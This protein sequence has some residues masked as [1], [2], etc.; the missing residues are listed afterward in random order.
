MNL[1]LKL[2]SCIDPAMSG[3]IVNRLMNQRQLNAMLDISLLSAVGKILKDF[4]LASLMRYVGSAW[5]LGLES[6]CILV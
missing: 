4:N 6:T 1:S 3:Y 2:N 5:T